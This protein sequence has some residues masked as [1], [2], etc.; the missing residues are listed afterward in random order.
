MTP[1]SVEA[2][3]EAVKLLHYI[4]L[5]KLYSAFPSMMKRKSINSWSEA[6]DMTELNKSCP[7]SLQTFCIFGQN[8]P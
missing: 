3:V 4:I 7:L 2:G 1:G 5:P 8:I 6:K